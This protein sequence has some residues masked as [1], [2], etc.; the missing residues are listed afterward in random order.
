MRI[1]V[2]LASEPFRKDRPILIASTACAVFLVALLGMLVFLIVNERARAKDTRVAVNRLRTE[3]KSTAAEQ[4]KLDE[5]LE[6][7]KKHGQDSLTDDER[8]VLFRAS[9]I[10]RKRRKQIGD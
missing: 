7:V 3:L 8:A 9:E 10:Y 2:N 4:A 1:P 5:V 6:K